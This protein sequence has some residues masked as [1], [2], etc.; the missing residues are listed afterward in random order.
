[1]VTL[2]YSMGLVGPAFMVSAFIAMIVS[3]LVSFSYSE[4]SSFM[5]GAGMIGDY[6]MVAMGP[7]MAIVS[8]LG[9]YIVLV[10]PQAPW[11]PLRQALPLKAW[12]PM[13]QLRSLHLPCWSCFWG[14]PDWRRSLWL[15]TG[16]HHRFHDYRYIHHGHHGPG[17]MG[18]PLCS[19]GYS[20]QP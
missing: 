8:V 20:F 18:D 17:R 14:K 6:T 4:L 11:S 10:S 7:F 9:G 15:S 13:Y 2:G 3:I 19:H 1:M 16:I 12:H 5:P